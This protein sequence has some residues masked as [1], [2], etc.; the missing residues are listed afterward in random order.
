MGQLGA[1]VRV[2]DRNA[3]KVKKIGSVRRDPF[4]LLDYVTPSDIFQI[5]DCKKKKKKK[6]T[7]RNK[8]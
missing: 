6:K 1:V 7:W 4:H 5:G 3:E 8:S 2:L